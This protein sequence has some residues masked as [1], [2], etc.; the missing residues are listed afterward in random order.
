M[1]KDYIEIAGRRFRVES[2]W[3]ALT[4]FLD[5]VG[6]DTLDELSRINT[7]RPS[8]LTALMAACIEE[9]ERLDGR[10]G[11]PSAKDLGAIITPDDVREF[12]TIYV[13]QSNPKLTQDE[14]KKEEREAE[15]AS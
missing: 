6:R 14:Q 11:A 9:G 3:N 12:L 2:N 7:I 15:P 10:D 8:E 4:A 5:A 13:R 1:K